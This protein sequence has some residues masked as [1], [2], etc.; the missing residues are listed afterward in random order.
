[1]SEMLK[2]MITEAELL[3][4]M[5]L[6]TSELS[7]LRLEKGLPFVKLTMRTRVYLEDE[8]MGWFKK[9]SI[10]LNKDATSFLVPSYAPSDRATSTRVDID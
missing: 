5:N 4:L 10:I 7:Y 8:L 9:H 1:M 3:K 6:K 2:G